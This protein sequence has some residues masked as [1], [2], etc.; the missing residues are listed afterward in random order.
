MMDLKLLG[1]RLRMIRKHLGMNQ[2]QLADATNLTQPAIS[3][4]EKGDEIYAS[5]LLAV[6][7]FYQ[8]KVSLHNLFSLD[9]STDSDALLYTSPQEMRQSLN[10]GLAEIASRLDQT[11]EQV[12]SLRKSI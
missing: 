12:E 1:E 5:T 10:N 8:D 2:Q 6:L 7:S 11:K 3:R 4:L 9:L